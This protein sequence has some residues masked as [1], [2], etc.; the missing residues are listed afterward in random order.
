VNSGTGSLWLGNIA[1]FNQYQSLLEWATRSV[2]AGY[3][4]VWQSQL[5]RKADYHI[6]QI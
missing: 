3:L 6:E 4:V 1:D 2:E 5:T